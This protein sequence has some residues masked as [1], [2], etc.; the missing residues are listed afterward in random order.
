MKLIARILPDKD[1]TGHTRLNA[2]ETMF[3]IHCDFSRRAANHAGIEAIT[4]DT[5]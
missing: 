1:G 2:R 4:M 5:E 3:L